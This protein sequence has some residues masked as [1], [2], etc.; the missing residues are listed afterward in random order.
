MVRLH[1]LDL[2]QV[3]DALARSGWSADSLSVDALLSECAWD[4]RQLQLKQFGPALD[5]LL[6]HEPQC[7]TP[8]LCH[9]DI[10][11][12]NLVIAEGAVTLQAGSERP[13]P[14]VALQGAYRDPR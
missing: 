12:L 10:H 5:W 4:T 14:R 8:V 2:T 11:G 9:G 6:Q 3:V 1:R 13:P 7:E